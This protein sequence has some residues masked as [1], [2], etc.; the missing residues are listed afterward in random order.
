MNYFLREMLFIYLLFYY[1]LYF[2]E[3]LKCQQDI[4]TW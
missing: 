4:S 3:I 2:Y 1:F